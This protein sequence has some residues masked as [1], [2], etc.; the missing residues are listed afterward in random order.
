MTG[1]SKWQTKCTKI[2]SIVLQVDLLKQ[3]KLSPSAVE[4]KH[5][6]TEAYV[7]VESMYEIST[8]AL[9]DDRIMHIFALSS[10]RIS[11]ASTKFF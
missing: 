8:R 9:E 7:Y 2:Y 10:R 4:K 5:F 3:I 11:P 1:F 6:Q